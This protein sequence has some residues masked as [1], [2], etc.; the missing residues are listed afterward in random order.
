MYAIRSYY[1][2]DGLGITKSDRID[3]NMCV[4]GKDFT[5]TFL[6][7]FDDL[8]NNDNAVE[9]IK[10][11]VLEQM[12]ILYKENTAEFI[13]FVTLYHIFEKYRNNFV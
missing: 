7:Q 13:Y 1:A 5:W 9:D 4:Y 8:W 12:S 3:S 11:Q 6:K 10:S 2:S